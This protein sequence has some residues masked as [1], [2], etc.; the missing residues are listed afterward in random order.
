M[1]ES[2]CLPTLPPV[3]PPARPLACPP[4]TSPAAHEVTRLLLDLQRGDADA[5]GQLVQFVYAELHGLAVHYMRNE[6][7]DHTLQ[8]TALVHEAYLRLSVKNPPHW[9]DRKHFYLAAASVM[10]S[11]LVNHAR[12][13]AAGKRGGA[14]S[15]VSLSLAGDVF[16]QPDLDVISLHEALERLSALDARKGQIVELK[17]FGGLTAAETAELLEVS[18]ATVLRDWRVAKAWLSRQLHDGT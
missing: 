5:S 4:V 7:G 2:G 13:R 3:R 16:R 14:A 1:V 9:N 11:I 6:R 10:R 12:D 17:F 8:P 15:P 18:E